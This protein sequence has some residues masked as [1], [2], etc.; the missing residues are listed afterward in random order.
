MLRL[1]MFLAI[2]PEIA[3]EFGL[4][5]AKANLLRFESIDCSM[6]L[7]FLIV[8]CAGLG[9]VGYGFVFSWLLGREYSNRTIADLLALPTSRS[10][11]VA[12]K[13]VTALF[14]CLTLSLTMY[15]AGL[16]AGRIIGFSGWE[17]KMISTRTLAY[18]WISV[19]TILVSTPGAFFASC[20]R[21]YL[22]P[23]GFIGIILMLTQFVGVLGLAPY[24]P[25]SIPLQLAQSTG[26]ATTSLNSTSYLI[27]ILTGILGIIITLLWWRWADQ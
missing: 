5:G 26:G 18:F 7:V 27:I 12:A 2:H 16:L 1:I 20:G 25:W 17:Q 6:Y 13:F 3:Q 23:I 19:L 11:I 21:G 10:A 9:L 24:F 22:L 15:G 8:A 14:W 4:V